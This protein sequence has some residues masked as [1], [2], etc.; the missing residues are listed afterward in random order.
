MDDE[1]K[2]IKYGLRGAEYFSRSMWN[3]YSSGER[4]VG[5][6]KAPKSFPS[7]RA[8]E[9]YKKNRN[10][11]GTQLSTI[12]GSPESAVETIKRFEK[13]GVDE[14][15]FVMQMGTVPHELIMESMETISKKVFPH[16][17]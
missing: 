15:I 9:G 12:I 7:E 2:A 4:H 14:I 17:K 1:D 6:V 5:P 13:I 10:A 11:P 3:Y 8:I 16:F